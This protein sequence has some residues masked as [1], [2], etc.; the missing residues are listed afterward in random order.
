[1]VIINEERFI[2]RVKKIF[3]N[4][5]NTVD[6]IFIFIAILCLCFLLLPDSQYKSLGD[7]LASDGNMERMTPELISVL[8][9]IF[10]LS[11]GIFAGLT[12]WHMYSADGRN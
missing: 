12:V 8:R 3:G 10:G 2:S 6:S 11:A 5:L 9:I 7:K 4:K 1:M